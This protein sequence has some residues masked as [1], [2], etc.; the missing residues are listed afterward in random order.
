MDTSVPLYSFFSA[1][2]DAC[3]VVGRGGARGRV[4]T[5]GFLVGFGLLGAVGEVW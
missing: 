4:L 1:L 3:G 2:V 5:S